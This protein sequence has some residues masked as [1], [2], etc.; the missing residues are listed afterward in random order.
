MA[1]KVRGDL[2]VSSCGKTLD[3]LNAQ[4]N[5]NTSELNRYTPGDVSGSTFYTNGDTHY[6]KL[7]YI[8]CTLSVNDAY[9]NISLLISSAFYGIQHWSTDVVT[10]AQAQYVDSFSQRLGGNERQFYYSIDTTNKRINLYVA[11]WGGN[12]FGTW[13]VTVLN[14]MRATW[15]DEREFNLTKGSTWLQVNPKHYFKDLTLSSVAVT[16]STTVQIGSFTIPFKGGYFISGNFP[17]NH[18]GQEGRSLHI[19]I[20]RNGTIIYETTSVYNV[21]AWTVSQCISYIQG[22]EAGDVIT[23]HLG[24][25]AAKN[26]ACGESRVQFLK[27]S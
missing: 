20:K 22:F 27:I 8:K 23:F 19:Q 4:I 11:V 9:S 10:I 1:L 18:Y 25:S 17:L 5:N 26:W 15:V 13:N 14:D 16:T 2:V 12:G 3:Q 24:S 7:G 21:Y 6:M